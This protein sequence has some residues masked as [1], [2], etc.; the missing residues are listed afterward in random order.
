[1]AADPRPHTARRPDGTED[2]DTERRF[3]DL[4]SILRAPAGE[5]PTDAESA[6]AFVQMLYDRLNGKPQ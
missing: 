2:L 6:L 5:R 1:M 4:F 3:Q